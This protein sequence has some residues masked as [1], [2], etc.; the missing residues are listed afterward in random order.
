MIWVLPSYRE[1]RQFERARFGFIGGLAA[2]TAARPHP[3]PTQPL[4]P[5]WTI[6]APARTGVRRVGSAGTRGYCR[7]RSRVYKSPTGPSAMASQKPK[8]WST[9]ATK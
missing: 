8:F 7:A 5:R 1:S 6:G 4:L 2:R 9:E 3:W